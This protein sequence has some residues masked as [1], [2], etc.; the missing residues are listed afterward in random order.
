MLM[1]LHRCVDNQLQLLPAKEGSFSLIAFNPNAPFHKHKIEAC[2]RS[3]FV[4]QGGPCTYCPQ[5]VPRSS[6]P[7]GNSTIL[8]SGSL[9]SREGPRLPCLLPRLC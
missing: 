8:S 1:H 4:T 9:V 7:P 3:F 5:S 2:N 6:C